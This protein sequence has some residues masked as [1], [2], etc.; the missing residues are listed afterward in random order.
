MSD[1]SVIVYS[2]SGNTRKVADA[3]AE[4]LGVK[5]VDV[6]ASHPDDAKIMFLGTGTYGS[7][8]GEDMMKFIESGNFTGRKVAIFYTSMNPHGNQKMENT[9]S[10]ALKQKGAAILGIYHCQGKTFLLFN[11]SHPTQEEL[12]NAKKFAKEMI[13]SS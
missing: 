10:D 11:R 12:D 7:K 9:L 1:I 13:K 5:A 2:R 6:K 8:A 3:I 4:E